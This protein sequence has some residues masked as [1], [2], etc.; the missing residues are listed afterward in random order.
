MTGETMGTLQVNNR[1]DGEASFSVDDM[2]ILEFAGEQLSEV[3]HGRE[4]IL[5][6][7]GSSGTAGSSSGAPARR[8]STHLNLHEEVQ[9]ESMTL[10]HSATVLSNFNVELLN[11]TLSDAAADAIAFDRIPIIEVSISLH[12]ALHKLCSSRVVYV[13]VPEG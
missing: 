1:T 2:K 9:G 13:E 7:F 12:L 11:L 3:L 10:V 4:D 5:V 8:A 6:H